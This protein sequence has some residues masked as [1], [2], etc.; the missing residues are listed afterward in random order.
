VVLVNLLVNL[1]EVRKTMSGSGKG[2]GQEVQREA[3][4]EKTRTFKVQLEGEDKGRKKERGSDDI[5]ADMESIF[6]QVQ[7]AQPSWTLVKPST[8]L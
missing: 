8:P 1:N 5:L 2:E 7:S 6:E 3:L 4:L